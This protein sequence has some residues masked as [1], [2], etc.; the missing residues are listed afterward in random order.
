MVA[1]YQK[2][3]TISIVILLGLT[4][5]TI[6]AYVGAAITDIIMH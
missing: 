3:L 5:G 1:L 6:A 4:I 2:T